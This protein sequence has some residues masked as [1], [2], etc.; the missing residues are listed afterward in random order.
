MKV[1]EASDVIL[2]V[3]DSRDPIGTRCVDMENIVMKSGPDKRLV[4][5]I[6]KIGML[7]FLPF[8]SDFM[9]LSFGD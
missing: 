1:I 7:S 6:N 8:F 5:L 9:V 2:K 4:L 3:L